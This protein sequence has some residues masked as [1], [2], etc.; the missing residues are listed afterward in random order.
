MP[1]TA[2][3][4]RNRPSPYSQPTLTHED[5]EYIFFIA[6]DVQIGSHTGAPF[7]SQAAQQMN[8]PL[9]FPSFNPLPA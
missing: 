8:G 6:D 3:V 5:R 9:P 4:F 2:L 1:R 7:P